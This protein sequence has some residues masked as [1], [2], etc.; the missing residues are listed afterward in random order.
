MI[1][2]NESLNPDL[3]NY[4]TFWPGQDKRKIYKLL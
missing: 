4:N 2:V 3:V 1:T